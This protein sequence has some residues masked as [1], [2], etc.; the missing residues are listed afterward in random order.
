MQ[1]I[2]GD[3]V[4]HL[5]FLEI[6]WL[7]IHLERKVFIY[8]SCN[9]ICVC[10]SWKYKENRGRYGTRGRCGRCGHHKERT[11]IWRVMM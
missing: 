6:E 8:E 1:P 10:T 2:S 7:T 4:L 5:S 11:W 9:C 3:R